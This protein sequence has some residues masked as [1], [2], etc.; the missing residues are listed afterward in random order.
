MPNLGFTSFPGQK[1]VIIQMLSLELDPFFYM[2]VERIQDPF[3]LRVFS[4]TTTQDP[5]KILPL[6]YVGEN[7]WKAGVSELSRIFV[8]S[9]LRARSRN[10]DSAAK[11]APGNI[12]QTVFLK[13]FAG[14]FEMEVE[15]PLY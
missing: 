14:K 13:N 6:Q 1:I 3:K 5:K 2:Q 15:I 8:S 12:F 4:S 7:I 11:V 10:Y 9:S